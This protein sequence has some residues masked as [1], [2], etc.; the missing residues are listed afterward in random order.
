VEFLAA[1]N[2]LGDLGGSEVCH[3]ER[4]VEPR[5]DGA[6]VG[7]GGRHGDDLDCL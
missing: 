7:E 3:V 1:F 5:S 2:V 6:E 4:C